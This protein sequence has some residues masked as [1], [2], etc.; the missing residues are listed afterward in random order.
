MKRCSTCNRTYTDPNLSF[1]IDDGTPLTPV[2]TDDETTVVKPRGNEDD[3]WNAVAYQPPSPPNPY[4]PPGVQAAKPRR[5]VWP[6][7]VGIGGAFILGILALSIFFIVTVQ[8]RFRESERERVGVSQPANSNTAENSNAN[9]NSTVN[10]PPPANHDQVLAHLKD[11]ENEWMVAN[12]NADKKKLDRILADDYVG[13]SGPEGGLETKAEYLKR[14][15]RDDQIQK[16]EMSEEKL[17]LTGDRAT[18]A[19]IV[20][21]F[22]R[23][24]RVGSFDFKDK[25]VWRDGRWQATGSELTPRKPPVG[26]DL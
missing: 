13:Q 20:T 9:S 6:W 4:A 8:R 3:D 23:D 26:T 1:C 16:W 21:F 12:V 10:T 7:V 5:R 11:L 25:F 24:G 2:A 14:T 15:E 19:G 17:T 22:L 18:L